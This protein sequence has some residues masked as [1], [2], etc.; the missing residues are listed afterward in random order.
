MP[1]TLYQKKPMCNIVLQPFFSAAVQCV[2][3]G[4][5]DCCQAP[6]AG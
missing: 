5:V 4:A 6:P 3:R 1:C 2:G